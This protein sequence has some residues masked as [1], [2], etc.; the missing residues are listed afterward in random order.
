M[1]TPSPFCLTSLPTSAGVY[2]Y[3]NKKEDII[4]VGKAKNLKKRISSYFTTQAQEHPKTKVLVNH[5]HQVETILVETELEALLLENR[6]IKK[7]RPKYNIY[8]KDD[9]TY[10]Y[11]YF[12]DDDIP[13]ISTKRVTHLKG[14]YFGPFVDGYLRVK[15]IEFCVNYFSIITPKTY[16]TY[17]HLN[18]EINQAPAKSIAE[19]DTKWYLKQVKEAQNF[20]H[21]RNIKKLKND[22][23]QKMKDYAKD[24]QFEYAKEQKKLLTTLDEIEHLEQHVDTLKKYNQDVL[25]CKELLDKTTQIILLHINKGSILKKKEFKIQEYHTLKDWIVRFY[26]THFPPHELIIDSTELLSQGYISSQ[27]LDE[28][29]FEIQLLYKRKIQLTAPKQGDKKKLLELA[30]KNLY[31]RLQNKS[32]LEQMK[33]KLHLPKLPKVI[34]C[35]DMS[36]FSYDYVV[37]A[38]VQFVDGVENPSEYRKFEIKSLHKKQDDFAAMREC[39]Y[40]R[41][42]KLKKEKLPYP[43]LIIIDGGLGQLGVSSQALKLLGLHTKIPIISLAK[44]EEEIFITH[45]KESYI[46]DKNSEMMRFIRH[47]RNSVH[48]YVVSYN[49]KKRQMRA[50]EEIK[51][52]NEGK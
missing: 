8:F 5:I 33:E 46:F 23:T 2:V 31:Y 6:L 17:S 42:Y 10:A 12:S 28:A 1:K 32:I 7:H 51:E 13:K 48:N 15:L 34:E 25:V 45:S 37:G 39:V 29:L 9:K 24:L 49:K 21:K 47:I 36:N 43:D 4:Y 18:Y 30:Y 35:F 27:E 41:Y 44:Q 20:L 26:S 11:I 50:K 40:R 14:K 22:I 38:M 52:I 3:K 16:S 19:I